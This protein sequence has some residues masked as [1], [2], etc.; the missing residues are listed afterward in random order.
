[1]F[2]LNYSKI[3]AYNFCNYLYKFLYID[4]K[5]VKHNSK[6]SFGISIHKALKE[7]IN[8]RNSL[9]RFLEVYEENWTNYGYSTGQEMMDYYYKG[10]DILK[11]FF[12]YERK[13][14]A[15]IVSSE[16]FF[17]CNISNDFILRGTVDRVD[18]KDDGSL[19]II[20]YKINIDENNENHIRN[21]LQLSIYAYGISRKYSKAVSE[22]VYYYVGNLKEFRIE[23]MGDEN[24]RNYLLDCGEKMKNIILTHKGNCYSCLAKELCQFS[25]YKRENKNV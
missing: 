20:D 12:E 17:E 16:D 19:K 24:L 14:N 13:R 15:H 5:Y 10:I 3:N 4:K 22:L 21:N 23:Y 11:R 7:Y 1:M 6:T 18:L 25:D 2:E 8:T 9:S